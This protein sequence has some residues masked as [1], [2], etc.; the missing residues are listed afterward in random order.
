LR[1]FGEG[2]DELLG[3]AVPNSVRARRWDRPV[4]A[5]RAAPTAQCAAGAAAATQ[6]AAGAAAAAQCAAARATGTAACTS[7][8]SPSADAASDYAA[9]AAPQRS[10]R[11]A[12][13]FHT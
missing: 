2:V 13:R 5:S 9:C 12:R 4:T 10:R 6:C 7:S 3:R 11:S 8:R 1:V